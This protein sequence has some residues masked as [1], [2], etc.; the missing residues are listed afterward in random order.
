MANLKDNSDNLNNN[1]D[2]SINYIPGGFVLR[3][4][5]IKNSKIST[6]TPCARETYELMVREATHKKIQ[7]KGYWLHKGQLLTTQQELIDKLQWLKGYTPMYYTKPQMKTAMK[8][9][10]DLGLINTTKVLA[11]T[12]ITIC[13]Y[14]YY[15]RISNYEKTSENPNETPM[16]TLSTNNQDALLNNKNIKNNKKI[17]KKYMI[18][19]KDFKNLNNNS[20]IAYK[21]WELFRN[22]AQELDLSIKS[23]ESAELEEWTKPIKELTDTHNK[24]HEEFQEVYQFLSKNE[25]WKGII[26]STKKLLEKD[27]NGNIY[28]DTLLLQKREE[29]EKNRLPTKEEI[30]IILSN[31]FKNPTDYF[32][33]L[34]LNYLEQFKNCL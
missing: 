11:G 21:F 23:I 28:F 31:H 17:K 4:R 32:I 24:V 1:E 22:R 33:E 14:E 6:A 8:T 5:C 19:I 13:N 10:R 9:L 7:Y 26:K 29:D 3:P 12:I 2:F 25:F 34:L 30:K 27:K 18:D 16:N 15:Q 20:K